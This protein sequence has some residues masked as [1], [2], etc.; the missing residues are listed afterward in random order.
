MVP[1][2][3]HIFVKIYGTVFEEFIRNT[4]TDRYNMICSIDAH[5]KYH[6]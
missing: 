6:P 3:T 5:E 1:G 4:R 2:I